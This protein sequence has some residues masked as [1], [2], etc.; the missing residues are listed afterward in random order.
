MEMIILII[1]SI[2][3]IL[4]FFFIFIFYFGFYR[5]VFIQLYKSLFICLILSIGIYN[6]TW[7]FLC[8]EVFR[9]FGFFFNNWL[10]YKGLYFLSNLLSFWYDNNRIDIACML[11]KIFFF[12]LEIS[13][14]DMIKTIPIDSIYVLMLLEEADSYLRSME[15]SLDN[16]QKIIE[17]DNNFYILR[18]RASYFTILRLEFEYNNIVENFY[19]FSLIFKSGFIKKPTNNRAF[20]SYIKRFFIFMINLENLKRFIEDL[21][22][23]EAPYN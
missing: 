21:E 9:Y 12:L 1:L 8:V 11:C 16:I 2:F 3:F 19:K 15:N 4:L 18:G 17:N 5:N 14:R 22:I 23:L 6:S 7:W 20:M 13:F 10:V